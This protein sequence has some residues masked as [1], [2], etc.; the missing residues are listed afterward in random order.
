MSTKLFNDSLGNFEYLLLGL[1]FLG[2]LYLVMKQANINVSLSKGDGF[3]GNHSIRFLQDDDAANRARSSPSDRGHEGMSMGSMEAPVW[4][5]TPT[6]LDMVAFEQAAAGVD[7]NEL[8]AQRA[9][10]ANDAVSQHATK[11]GVNSEGM[12]LRSGYS[13]KS[14]E[15]M[16]SKLMGAMVGLG[17]NLQ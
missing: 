13:K 4:H 9:F 17:T 14:V 5:A 6:N 10:A 12:G 15:S 16:D 8:S 7:Y 1:T 11:F 3:A 2:V